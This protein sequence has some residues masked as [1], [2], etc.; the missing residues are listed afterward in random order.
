[1]RMLLKWESGLEATNEAIRTGKI[2][3]LNELINKLTQPEAAYFCT[4]NGRRTSY[5]FFDMSDTSQI[6][7][8][9]EPLFQ[10][11][12][13]VVEFIP[14]MNEAEL[15]AGLGQSLKS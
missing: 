15:Q 13:A 3:E 1:M 12:D 5:M 10:Q 8:I 11:L 9:A 2:A 7:V 6:P 4:E 14:V